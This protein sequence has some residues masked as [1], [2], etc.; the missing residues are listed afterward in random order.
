M[1]DFFITPPFTKE[2][3]RHAPPISPEYM[4]KKAQRDLLL[5][6]TR[7]DLQQKGFRVFK[8]SKSSFNFIALKNNSVIFIKV[9]NPLSNERLSEKNLQ[10]FADKY[11]I[12]VMFISRDGAQHLFQSKQRRYINLKCYSCGEKSRIYLS[13]DIVCKHCGK[14][15]SFKCWNCGY[16]FN[17]KDAE[18]C[19]SCNRFICPQCR[20]CG[21]NER[22]L[23]LEWKKSKAKTFCA[24][25]K[26]MYQEMIKTKYGY[27]VMKKVR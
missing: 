22:A 15:Y 6:K 12:D 1:N 9:Y 8:L 23:L 14:S 4:K 3:V 27:L 11:G 25:R 26:P 7:Q 2:E 16:E 21:C 13:E 17:V 19:N 5:Q 18:Y 24:F 10:R 20:S